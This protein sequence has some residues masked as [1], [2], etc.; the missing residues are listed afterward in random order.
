LIHRPTPTRRPFLQKDH[1]FGNAI[2]FLDGVSLPA[3]NA[4]RRKE[5]QAV[6]FV[7]SLVG[8]SANQP[9]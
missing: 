2:D 4:H 9:Y 3:R 7:L 5:M 8:R 1:R 6:H